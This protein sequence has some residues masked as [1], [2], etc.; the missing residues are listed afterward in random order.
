MLLVA[1]TETA[2]TQVWPLVGRDQELRQLAAARAEP[3]CPAVVI[4]AAAGVGKSRLAREAYAAA[5][6][7]GMPAV[8][9]QA[10]ASSATIPLGA[11][12]G[13]IPDEVRSDDPFELVRR[14]G[15]AL[16]ARGEGRPV[17]LVVDDAQLLDPASATLLLQLATTPVACVVV[18]VR[19]GEP[20][21]DAIDSL[22]KDA[23]ARR[24]ELERLPDEA[25]SELVEA[26]LA[27]PVAQATM[28][29]IIDVCA[30]N[31]LYAREVVLEGLES[32]RLRCDRGLWQLEGPPG[33][34]PS[35][36]TLITRRIGA[37]DEDL[38]ELLEL[39]A[40][41]EP[42]LLSELGTV[43]SYAA[44]EAAEE[45]GMIVVAGPSEDAHVGL[46]H[47]IYGEV[48]RAEL[49]MI[50][51]RS[52]RL[53]LAEVI[54]R[55]R[56]LTPD[57]SLRAA[58]WLIT[59][60][61]EIP[62]ELLVGA[63][64]A[65]NLS[66]DSGLGAEL[67]RRAIDGGAGI[68]AVLL[69]ARAHTNRDRF[70]DANAVLA[71]AE[72]SAPG[73]PLASEYFEQRMHVLYWGLRRSDEALALLDRA[74]G[75]S[76]DPDWG[77][78]LEP[79]RVTIGG[80]GEG[81]QL[82]SIDETLRQ[83]DLD[84]HVRRG[85]ENTRGM[86]L[87]FAGRV[88]E[89]HELARRLRPI[90][91]L[92]DDLDTYALGLTVMVGE[93]SG[94][95]RAELRSYLDDTFRGAI[96]DGDHETAGIAAFTFGSLDVDDGRY[97][98]AARWLTEAEIHLEYKDSFETVTAI[99]ALQVG[100]A[101]LTS[102]P[103]AAR[104][105]AE[106]MRHRISQRG[107][108]PVLR[109]WLA[110]GEG[111][112][113]RARSDAEG[114]ELFRELAGAGVDPTMHSRLLH[115]ALRSG[116][117]PG[118][119]AQQLS[120]LADTCDSRLMEARAA[121]ATALADRNGAA[122]IDAGEQLAACGCGAAAIEAVLA[123]ARALLAEGRSDSARRAAVRARELHP[124]DQGWDLPVVDGLGGVAVELTVREQQVATLVA[125][126]LTSQQIA[127]ELVLSVRTV[128]TYIYRAMQKRGVNN[129]RDL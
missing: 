128:E 88:R 24:I 64:A 76:S 9:A 30:G 126:G 114:A 109:I 6:A 34:T 51:A 117:R 84:P 96:R 48:I 5:Q 127:D 123:G 111:W 119:L 1:G 50:R 13:V 116:A 37:V 108:R 80:F 87:L 66:G 43:T 58:R 67:A 71:A 121:H 112:A 101:C 10:T 2:V 39:L 21:P 103:V 105:A 125:R 89:A 110:C 11:L 16:R 94:E 72:A 53:R 42:L 26:A 83:P 49:P 122:L 95:D 86:A 46:A 93:E 54:Q 92:R 33:V 25:I 82:E 118:P 63:A 62:N 7:D 32:G 35:L 56:P 65:A 45:R 73:D 78:A 74:T 18:T 98:D 104:T 61:A 106:S 27:G 120:E 113:A 15:A 69:L 77:A 8:W 100:I 19:L 12:A 115:E 85:L 23:G 124:P 28:S 44:L 68:R 36:T 4:T 55:R 40:L 107:A 79:W 52:H 59:A 70:D 29:R 90:T 97:R 75:W 60:G 47:P 41:G 31:P 99:R 81:F 20:T 14:S 91:P 57:D 22:W 3:G 102:E 38:R 129:R 17:M